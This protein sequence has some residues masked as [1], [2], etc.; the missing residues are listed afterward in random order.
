[1]GL[2]N[3]NQYSID[4]TRRLFWRTETMIMEQWEKIYRDTN[5][6]KKQQYLE[7]EA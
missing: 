5:G 3:I 7:E 4:G 6:G 2:A 1:L